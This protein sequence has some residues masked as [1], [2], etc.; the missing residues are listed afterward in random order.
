MSTS[1]GHPP[2]IVLYNPQCVFY[3]MPLS[4]VAVGSAAKAAGYHVEII[5]ARLDDHP[6]E[7]VVRSCE[8]A[9]CLG[10]TL[11]TGR[12][13][14]DALAVSRAVK[15]AYP[16]LPV[17]V[18]GA[19]P[20]IFPRETIEEPSF[21]IAVAG[22]GEA[23]FLE[24]LAALREGEMPNCVP[25]VHVR[26]GAVP[27]GDGRRTLADVNQYAPLDYSLI[28]VED[29]FQKKGRRQLDYISSAG[30]NF[31]CAFCSEPLVNNRRW[32][33]LT[34]ERVGEELEVLVRQHGVEDVN[35]QDEL[36][37]TQLKR[38]RQIA[39]ELIRRDLRVSW[40][41]TLRADQCCR[42][43]DED[44]EL[45]KRSGLRRVLIGVEAGSQAM[46]DH[47]SKRITVE[48]VLESARRCARHEIAG[49]FGHIVG[50]PGESDESFW[51]TLNMARTIRGMSSKFVTPI[52]YY[53]PYP[54]SSIALEAE[55]LGQPL[56]KTLE[57]WAQ[58]DF[59]GTLGPWISPERGRV[60]EAFKFY[61]EHRWGGSSLRHRVLSA[62]ARWRLAGHRYALPFE[63]SAINYLFPK[64]QLS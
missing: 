37:F 6:L 40:A 34:P 27:P 60:V 20:S 51:A 16:S 19:H 54:G 32:S 50:F 46:M 29:Y 4:L 42:L 26:G 56:P 28:P 3:T 52:F 55:Q 9:L 8:G 41:A 11:L 22:Q 10:I 31:D 36:F 61:N 58:F 15:A 44:F 63:K 14:V 43:S 24:I 12:P 39:E 17:V 18:G 64:A 45:F 35:F 1:V 13:I 59:V 2:K 5:D 38:S 30:C 57:E 23:A 49:M 62:A 48:E 21:D 53:K 25:G 7:S 47:I 33:G